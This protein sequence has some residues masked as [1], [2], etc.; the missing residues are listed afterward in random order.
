MV[1]DGK[2]NVNS[3]TFE[4]QLEAPGRPVRLLKVALKEARAGKAASEF[5]LKTLQLEK[6][7]QKKD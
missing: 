6:M 7:F 2:C 1:S 5:A 4:S 3:G